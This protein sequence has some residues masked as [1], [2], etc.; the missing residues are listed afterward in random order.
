MDRS[1]KSSRGRNRNT[2]QILPQQLKIVFGGLREL[3]QLNLVA[4]S[5]VGRVGGLEAAFIGGAI[6]RAATIAGLR[7]DGPVLRMLSSL[8][9]HTR[10]PPDKSP[11][12]TTQQLAAL[13]VLQE[14]V[15]SRVLRQLS[16][17]KIIRLRQ[18]TVTSII[19]WQLDH[20]YLAKPI[21]QLDSNRNSLRILLSENAARYTESS[22]ILSR[23]QSLLPVFVQMKMLT[24]KI[25]GTLRYGEH[26]NYALISA[27]RVL[28]IVAVV[29]VAMSVVW[30][31]NEY[32]AASRIEAQLSFMLINRNGLTD[33]A[34]DGCLRSLRHEAVLHDGV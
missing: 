20:A 3:T 1:T 10:Q 30:V 6:A 15:T 5:R 2:G 13:S 18:D 19:A 11:P 34:A 26:R 4:Y 23:W 21:L 22:S 14:E 27:L 33:D 7:S 25:R 31:A 16:R 8:V 9:D 17:D 29:V 12:K 32:E 28:P 24:A